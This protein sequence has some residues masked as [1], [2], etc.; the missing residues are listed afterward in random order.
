MSP[1]DKFKNL[2]TDFLE[3]L[4]AVFPEFVKK[5]ESIDYEKYYVFCKDVYP[6]HFFD[7]LYKNENMFTDDFTLLPNVN[8]KEIFNNDISDESKNKIWQYLQLIMLTITND[9]DNS[10]DFGEASRLFDLLDTNDFKEKLA[11]TFKNVNTDSFTDMSDVCFD[12]FSAEFM[13]G[14]SGE[15]FADSSFNPE[16]IHEHISKLMNGKIGN[17]AKELAT[18]TLEDLQI[19]SS[20]SNSKELFESLV[21]DPTKLAEMM[22]KIGDKLDKKMK[23]GELSQQEIM[24]EASEMFKNMKNMPGFEEMF[25]KMAKGKAGRNGRA[26]SM[27]A[28]E[29]LLEKNMRESKQRQKML[30]RLE[31]KRTQKEEV[32]SHKVNN[33]ESNIAYT[34]EEIIKSFSDVISNA[35]PT[36]KP[37]NSAAQKGKKAKQKKKK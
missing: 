3:D 30:E 4:L 14:L 15:S 23:S 18:D 24:S 1:S 21:K 29:S 33:S 11:E 16:T 7:I 26:P 12:D 8:F 35:E 37:K 34:D 22:K 25:N 19:D 28:V 32:E 9:I 17:L 13:N 6:K 20:N 31:Q 27:N 5:E 10:S 2:I 36:S